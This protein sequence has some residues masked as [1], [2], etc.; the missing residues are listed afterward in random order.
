[1]L[2][3]DKSNNPEKQQKRMS[4]QEALS[5]ASRCSSSP[6]HRVVTAAKSRQGKLVIMTLMVGLFFVVE[7]VA[8]YY[9]NSIALQVDAVHMLS[10]LLALITAFVAIRKAKEGMDHVAVSSGDKERRHQL[11]NT[12]G[13]ARAEVLGALCNGVFLLGLTFKT[14]IEAITGFVSPEDVEDPDLI[15]IVGGAGLA[16][17][18]V[19][20]VLFADVGHGH[21]HGGGG[22]GHSHGEGGVHKKKEEEHGDE[23]AMKHHEK[24]KNS[25]MNMR[26][27]FL[28][29]LSDALACVVVMI[30]A[31]AFK[32]GSDPY[33]QY[34]DPLL[35][36]MIGLF[37]MKTTIPLV[38]EAAMLLLQGIPK[39]VDYF[40]LL[41]H[42]LEAH[43]DVISCHEVHVWELAEGRIVATAHL[44]CTYGSEQKHNQICAATKWVFH[45]FGIHSTTLQLEYA[46]SVAQEEKIHSLHQSLCGG[47]RKNS[48]LEIEVDT[49]EDKQQFNHHST[50]KKNSTSGISIP[51]S[52]EEEDA[53]LL[54]W[55]CLMACE[56]E[57]CAAKMCCN[58]ERQRSLGEHVEEWMRVR[59]RNGSC[60]GGDVRS[61]SGDEE[62]EE[63]AQGQGEMK[64]SKVDVVVSE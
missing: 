25:E 33:R 27:V 45:D 51:E 15:L 34:A 23:E 18:I 47:D 63:R 5:K 44:L 3:S 31:L 30:S 64:G 59:S 22:H 58:E 12:F 8:G 42:L 32:Y 20:L 60:C 41:R 21:S 14:M 16:M 55:Q 29:V 35:S 48:Q 56:T 13:W 53:P 9:A 39:S 11:G 36:L 40:H 1:M 61:V 4:D 37:I 43:P 19:G 2:Q 46:R 24:S 49:L 7:L 52:N 6:F 38:K 17:N 62:E 50:E 10:D 57:S 26:G 54:G 28:H